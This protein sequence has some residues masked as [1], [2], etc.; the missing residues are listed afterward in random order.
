MILRLRA[1]AASYK[2]L[3]FAIAD[4]ALE[5]AP[6]SAVQTALEE[7]A[8]TAAASSD[9]LRTNSGLSTEEQLAV[10][11]TITAAHDACHFTLTWRD[12]Q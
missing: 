7:M 1:F 3:A 10:R 5:A 4:A 6:G 8:A 12:D 11:T 9:A 2:L